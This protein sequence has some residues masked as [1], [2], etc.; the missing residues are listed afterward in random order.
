MTVFMLKDMV[1][2][3]FYAGLQHGT[4]QWGAQRHSK[5][6]TDRRDA[7]AA[8]NRMKLLYTTALCSYELVFTGST[9][10]PCGDG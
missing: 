6:Y 4:E 1:T 9:C 8:Q 7:L 10:L 3:Y 5:I 2:G